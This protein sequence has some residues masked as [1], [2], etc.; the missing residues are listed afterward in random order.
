MRALTTRELVAATRTAAVPVA[1]L[2]LLSAGAAF[3]LIWAPRMPTITTT[4]L[5]EQARA[6]QWILLAAVLPWMAVRSSPMDRLDSIALMAAVIA[7]RPSSAVAAKIAGAFL[8][9][10][11]VV[12]A[13]LPAL[14]LAQQAA[15]VPL[16]AVF[17]DLLPVL[18]LA[19]LV[20]ATSVASIVL[21][22]DGLRAAVWASVV[23]LAV[24]L[25][26][27]GWTSD[28]WKAG[29]LCAAAG[30]VATAFLCALAGGSANMDATDAR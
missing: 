19:L 11:F 21:A 10:L 13:G 2:L 29:V 1:A 16:S 23:V 7:A 15:A 12:F 26:A 8:V 24:L 6:V 9:Q 25:S 5:Y 28:L 30:I 17:A 22:A 14:V 20:A 3:V 27:L 18:G 4:N